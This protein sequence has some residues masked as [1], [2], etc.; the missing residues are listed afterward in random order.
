MLGIAKGR[1]ES[2]ILVELGVSKV[3]LKVH[4]SEFV[5]I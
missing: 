5:Y 1:S 4:M 3:Y 2:V